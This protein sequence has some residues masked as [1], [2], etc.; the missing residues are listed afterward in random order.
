MRRAGCKADFA[1][2]PDSAQPIC[3][4]KKTLTM[5]HFMQHT[6][7]RLTATV[8]TL[9]CAAF[10][11][12]SGSDPIVDDGPDTPAT[13]VSL[14]VTT[15]HI[16]FDQ[17]ADTAAITVRS[18]CEWTFE[19]DAEWIH[20]RK[21]NDNRLTIEVD[22]N[23]GMTTREGSVEVVASPQVRQQ[24][25]I[26]QLGWGK[27]I[28]LSAERATVAAEGG[29]VEVEVTA[30]FDVAAESSADWLREVADSRAHPAES[31]KRCFTA[32]YNAGS[33]PRT[34]VITFSEATG[35]GGDEF[36]PKSFTVT[37]GTLESE[38]APIG[39]DDDL[40]GFDWSELFADSSCTTLREGIGEAEI[41]ACDCPFFRH[42]AAYIY[43]GLYPSEFRAAAYRCY[44]HPDMQSK[45]NKTSPLSLHDNPT[46]M[47]VDEGEELILLARL[48]GRSVRLRVVDFGW[49]NG[50]GASHPTE[51]A[52][53]EGVNRLTM[54]LKGLCYI[55]Y[56]YNDTSEPAN[57]VRYADE[58][59]IGIHFA[60]GGTV[61]GYYDKC[62]ARLKNRGQ[63][64]LG[65]A[66]HPYFDV[67]GEYTHLIYPTESLRNATG[68]NHLGDL[69][70]AYD[71]LVRHETQLL[72]LHKHGG[73]FVNRLNFCVINWQFMYSTNYHTGYHYGTM[74]TMCSVNGFRAD[75]WGPSHEV[76][77]VT[78]TRPGLK[79]AGMTE[80][81]NNIMSQYI[82]THVDNRLSRLQAQDSYTAAWNTIVV[83]RRPHHDGGT[84]S[85]LVPFWQ[86]QLYFGDVL[87]RTPQM[88][89]DLG[90]FYPDVYEY[91]RKNPN[92]SYG[93][94]QANFAYV[95]SLCAGMDLTDFF[96]KWGYLHEIDI[97]VSDNTTSGQLTVTKEYADD[98]RARIAALNLPRPEV[99]LEYITDNNMEFVKE[100]AAVV[101]GKAAVVEGGKVRVE[102]WQ[103]VLAYEVVDG[104]GET[105]RAADAS[106]PSQSAC[107]FAVTLPE[108]KSWADGYGLYAVQYDNVRHKVEIRLAE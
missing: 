11:A 10:A 24:I 12:C 25:T 1:P 21:E 34:A 19:A 58:P 51:Y 37:Q 78:Q 83:P 59:E 100:R 62:D 76:G 48:H 27:D 88:Q 23:D 49:A 20:G 82:M 67:V 102:D 31:R 57:Y 7:T 47:A 75:R 64:L 70:E 77:H 43:R 26:R 96:E 63:E 13:D 54:R 105:I 5:N 38:Y 95:A 14:N 104:N 71:E 55:M 33:E 80:C 72:G 61:N 44:P 89:E 99:A 32:R 101:E 39:T 17:T 50:D 106:L 35:S 65:R 52:L 66:P 108:G 98:V 18:N 45:L 28:L 4:N 85:C 86:L 74:G 94:S 107:E 42:L 79:W 36:R 2:Q 41:E 69:A 6:L 16:D 97:Y 56:H 30:N 9:L 53:T 8:A 93:E 29:T 92:L 15:R 40:S 22:E 68:G 90:G 103:N 60:S 3:N 84:T 73:M 81:T 87:G 46:G 91:I